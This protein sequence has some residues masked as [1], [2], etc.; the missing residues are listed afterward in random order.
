MPTQTT[1]R[2]R[3]IQILTNDFGAYN[4]G[5]PSKVTESTKWVGDD[6]AELSKKFPPSEVYGADPLDHSEIE[7]GLIRYDYRFEQFVDGEWQ[8][9]NDPRVRSQ[10]GLTA[11]ERAIDAENRRLYPGDYEEADDEYDRCDNCDRY[12]LDCRC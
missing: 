11:L 10:R 5:S 1:T 4:N 3:V 6:I 8:E 7:D 9:C 2:V 12:Y